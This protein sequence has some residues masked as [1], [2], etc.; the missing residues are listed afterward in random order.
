MKT[1]KKQHRN[2]KNLNKI[3]GH[4][5]KMKSMDYCLLASHP[6]GTQ[7][8]R[9]RM[10]Y[11]LFFLKAV[12]HIFLK[13]NQEISFCVFFFSLNRNY[14]CYISNSIL[15]GAQIEKHPPSLRLCLKIINQP[16]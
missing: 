2:V 1:C 6:Q 10:G 7:K 12:F 8:L 9:V 15:V 16:A 3:A 14:S 13:K 4:L 5:S 11:F